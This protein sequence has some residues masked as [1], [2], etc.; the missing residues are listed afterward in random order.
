MKKKD[1]KKQQALKAFAEKNNCDAVLLTDGT[2]KRFMGER[3]NAVT[4]Y[5]LTEQKFYNWE[6]SD[7]DESSF[8]VI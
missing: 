4:I 6:I 2:I 1:N 5:K 8:N 3:Y 7:K